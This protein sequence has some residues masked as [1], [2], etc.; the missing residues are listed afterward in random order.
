MAGGRNPNHDLRKVGE[1]DVELVIRRAKEKYPEASATLIPDHGPQY[2]SK[3]FKTY[4][5]ESGFQHVLIAAGYPQINRK[6]ERFY[7]TLKSEKIRQSSFVDI[8]DARTQI[9][10]YVAY[11]NK[12]RLH[13]GI[14][15]LTRKE[16][17]EA[18]MKQRLAERKQSWTMHEE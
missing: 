4:I 12:E 13:S 2:I 15:Y 6:M 9:R 1:Y 8:S 11:Y 17:L 16:V 3:D 10:E 5:R 18:K 14:Y 7:R